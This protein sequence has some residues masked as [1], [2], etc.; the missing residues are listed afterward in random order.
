MEKVEAIAASVVQQ[1]RTGAEHYRACTGGIREM[2]ET[3]NAVTAEVLQA[4]D[5]VSIVWPRTCGRSKMSSSLASAGEQ[6]VATHARM[7]EIVQAGRVGLWPAKSFETGEWMRGGST[8]ED[9]F[10]DKYQPIGNTRPAKFKTRFDDFTDQ[11]VAAA[12]GESAATTPLAD[13]RYL[14]STA[15]ATCQR[16]TANSRSR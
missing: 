14:L 6:A 11:A 8:I 13:L 2:A 15:T 12:A 16:T 4:V 1:S 5:H 3:N 7:P 10:D 9:L